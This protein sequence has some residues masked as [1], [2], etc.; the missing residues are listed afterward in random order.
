MAK[1]IKDI[2]YNFNGDRYLISNIEYIP[3]N[4][5]VDKSYNNLKLALKRDRLYV[6][7]SILQL[8]ENI[9]QMIKDGI[10]KTL[11]IQEDKT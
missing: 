6:I 1:R 11:I 10:T 3:F 8:E 4:E 2:I 5:N 7:S 9:T